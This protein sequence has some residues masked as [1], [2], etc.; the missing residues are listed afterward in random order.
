[1]NDARWRKYATND[2]NAKMQKKMAQ[3]QE[4]LRRT[5]CRNSWWRYGCRN[6]NW[7]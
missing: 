3:E 1:M 7:S 5:Y 2:A 6:C 4:N